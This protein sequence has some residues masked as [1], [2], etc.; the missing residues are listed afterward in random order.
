MAASAH[1]NSTQNQKKKVIDKEVIGKPARGA[2]LLTMDGQMRDV[3]DNVLPK[4]IIWRDAD[5]K[6]FDVKD[7]IAV[8][9]HPNIGVI[10]DYF[11][12]KQGLK[13]YD[14]KKGTIYLYVN[15]GNFTD[16][17]WAKVKYNLEVGIRTMAL[18]H[19]DFQV[20]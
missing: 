6:F 5:N 14:G 2:K 1:A 10:Y 7:A 20:H 16:S 19:E 8:D 3:D 18:R 13:S 17:R 11:K 9:T 12:E 15:M 4:P